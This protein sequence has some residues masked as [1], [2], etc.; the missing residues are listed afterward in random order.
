MSTA[1][2]FDASKS[3][4]HVETRA[5]GMLAKL[6]HDLSLSAT[7]L[8]A[9]ATLEGDKLALELDVP[10]GGLRVDGVRKGAH[11]DKST[12]SA[13]DRAEIERKIRE[14]VLRAASVIVRSSCDVPASFLDGGSKELEA[15]LTVEVG[16]GRSEVRSRASVE[17]GADSL[18]GRGSAKVSM[19]SLGLAPVKGP[20]GAF[21]VDD[22][23]EI[24]YE[25]AFS[26]A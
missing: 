25:L 8:A 2:T 13:S 12:L 1:L 4:L 6:A 15:K 19:P 9:K 5:K 22:D 26:R 24:H 11:V 10:V 14:E 23:I 17:V 7:V 21:R 16:R 18:V 3:H 20:L